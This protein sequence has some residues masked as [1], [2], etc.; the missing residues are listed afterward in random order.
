MHK[1]IKVEDKH[2]VF[3]NDDGDFYDIYIPTLG[4][5]RK[6]NGICYS[7]WISHC[8]DL[9]EMSNDLLYQLAFFIKKYTP[10]TTIDWQEQFYV[11]ERASYLE[12]LQNFK[13]EITGGSNE[14]PVDELKSAME[15]SRDENSQ[16]LHIAL[17]KVVKERLKDYGIID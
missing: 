17:E 9:T 7:E 11:V 6:Q 5:V 2:L 4:E 10:L 8:M 14:N 1:C 13:Q 3:Y 15:I 16:E 12:T